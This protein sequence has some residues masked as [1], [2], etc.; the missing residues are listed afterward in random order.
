MKQI[1]ASPTNAPLG[2]PK[3]YSG[4]TEFIETK[5]RLVCAAADELLGEKEKVVP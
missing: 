2:I 1:L 3:K 4:W 5:Q